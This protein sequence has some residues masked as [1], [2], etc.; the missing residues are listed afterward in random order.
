MMFPWTF[1]LVPLVSRRLDK[2]EHL[3][4]VWAI[5][6]FVFFSLS[7]SKLPAYILPMAAPVALLLAREVTRPSS[8]A[9]FRVAVLIEAAVWSSIGVVAT[10]FGDLISVEIPIGG[11]MGLLGLTLAIAAVLVV[12]AFRLSPPALG[13][14]NAVTVVG[15]VLILTGLVFPGAQAIQSVRPWVSELEQIG[16][17]GEQVLLY[18]PPRWMEYG[19]DFY[20]GA[21][22]RTVQGEDELIEITESGARFI[23]IS[24]T[25][26]MEELSY[27]SD[28]VAIEVAGALGSQTAFW[29]W[30]P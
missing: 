25:S 24:E 3:L 4:V 17:S 19:F 13:I 8:S 10:F 9:R 15:L 26:R 29:C 28:R 2:N 1:L 12:I 7:G 21:P 20:L 16:V 30:Q 6:P 27:A 22:P 18:R 11:G 23:C 14:F 5:V